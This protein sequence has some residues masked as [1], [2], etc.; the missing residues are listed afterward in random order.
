MLAEAGTTSLRIII[1]L[2]PCG[3]ATITRDME[4]IRNILAR[5]EARKDAQPRLLEMPEVYLTVLDQHMRL[6]F[7]AGFIDGIEHASSMKDSPDY[8]MRDLTWE[9]H[10]FLA[11]LKNETVWAKIKAKLSPADLA[12]VPF[13]VL[14]EVASALLLDT[15]KQTFG[16]K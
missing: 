3:R 14:K 12:S 10:D 7:Q 5:V 4:L 16:L 6:L 9:G 8:S 13:A 1:A 15:L 11:A 2:D